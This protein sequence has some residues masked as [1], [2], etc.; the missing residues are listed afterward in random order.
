MNRRDDSHRF[1][2]MLRYANLA[3]ETLSND[4][5]EQLQQDIVK[6]AALSK[7]VENVGEAAYKMQPGSLAPYPNIDR[8]NI[9]NMRHRLVHE[10]YDIR[11]DIRHE[12]ITDYWPAMIDDLADFS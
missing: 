8:R 11:L 7:F 4:P 10:Y 1:G 2:D 12:V 3:I 9:I 6:A 5:L